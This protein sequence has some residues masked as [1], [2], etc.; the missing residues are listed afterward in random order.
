[1]NSISKKVLQVFV[2]TNTSGV[3][4]VTHTEGDKCPPTPLKC[5]V[6]F[7]LAGRRTASREIKKN[8]L[9]NFLPGDRL[10]CGLWTKC[11][12]GSTTQPDSSL[13]AVPVPGPTVTSV[14][15][16]IRSDAACEALRSVRAAC[17]DAQ[18][19]DR[20]LLGRFVAVTL[21][22]G[23]TVLPHETAKVTLAARWRTDDSVAV[24]PARTSCGSATAT[25]SSTISRVI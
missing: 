12:S 18:L 13:R 17:R 22:V 6:V 19:Q 25:R 24:R 14:G 15:S 4:R 7:Y 20:W 16:V 5:E 3:E 10:R 21:K 9:V 23:I 8:K 1:M 11:S 2:P